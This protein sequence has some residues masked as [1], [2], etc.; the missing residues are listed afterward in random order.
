MVK[1]RQI[2][3]LFAQKGSSGRTY[4]YWKPEKRLRQLGYRNRSLGPDAAEAARLAIELNAAIEDEAPAPGHNGPR[5]HSFAQL[6]ALYKASPEYRSKKPNTRRGY[7]TWLAQLSEWAMDG[8]LRMDALD[9]GMIRDLKAELL[10]YAED[11]ELRGSTNKCAAM[12]T[13]LRMLLKW[14]V[15]NDHMPANPMEGIA[16]P[17]PRPRTQRLDWPTVEAAAAHAAKAGADYAPLALPLAFWTLQRSTDQRLRFRKANWVELE[18]V[19]AEDRDWLAGEDGRVMG[20][21]LKGEGKTAMVQHVPVPPMLRP[22][23]EAAFEAREYLFP[24]LTDDAKPAAE[25]KYA[26][27]IRDALDAAGHPDIHLHD[28]KRSGAVWMAEQGAHDDDILCLSGNS[29]EGGKKIKNVY[30]PQTTRRACRALA[31]CLRGM[32]EREKRRAA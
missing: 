23:I 26:Q 5:S 18:A 12:L 16:V 9:K 19:N 22:A 7:D 32:A 3:R 29:V 30:L 13:T 2:P 28:M 11:G 15:A 4:H 27:K 8:A 31:D 14:A 1:R 17:V 10:D 24:Q 21:A 20:F 25:R 6:V